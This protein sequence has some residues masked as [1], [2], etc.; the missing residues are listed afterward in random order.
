MGELFFSLPS[1]TTPPTP[2][3]SFNCAAAVVWLGI[4]WAPLFQFQ[5][6]PWIIGTTFHHWSLSEASVVHMDHTTQVS[7]LVKKYAYLCFTCPLLLNIY[8]TVCAKGDYGWYGW[9]MW[10]CKF[11]LHTMFIYCP[12]SGSA[13]LVVLCFILELDTTVFCM[14]VYCVVFEWCY[15]CPCCLLLKGKT[16]MFVCFSSFFSKCTWTGP[17]LQMMG[18][19]ML[20]M[21][22]TP[23]YTILTC[24]LLFLFLK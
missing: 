23:P 18:H 4:L 10:W 21:K 15:T 11:P 1:L 5:D 24:T 3:F 20:S 2:C 7:M 22:V 9:T 6:E 14:H 8:R 19:C 13:F 17:L 12:L 16:E